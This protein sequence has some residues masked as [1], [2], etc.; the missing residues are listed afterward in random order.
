MKFEAKTS[1]WGVRDIQGIKYINLFFLE[2]MI[3]LGYTAYF[4]HNFRPTNG[5]NR[6][7]QGM[8]G[9]QDQKFRKIYPWTSC[10]T[11]FKN[12]LMTYF[13]YS[14]LTYQAIVCPFQPS[15]Q[16]LQYFLFL[17]FY[18]STYVLFSVIGAIQIIQIRDLK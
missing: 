6:K 14:H 17:I 9:T 7:I 5:V 1:E 3:M 12:L 11:R 18:C 10:R 16:V 15:C 4:L 2:L 8:M 13:L